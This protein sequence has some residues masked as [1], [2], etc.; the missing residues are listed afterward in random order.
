MK[1]HLP[2]SLG[3]V[4]SLLPP[5]PARP[6]D[7]SPREETGTAGPRPLRISDIYAFK[8]V[9]DP[10]ISPDGAWVAY[11]VK[12]LDEKEDLVE[13]S[14]EMA[15]LAGGEALPLTRPRPGDDADVRTRTHPRWSPDGKWLAFLAAREGKK[16]QVWLLPRAGGDSFPLTE[17]KAAVSDLAWSP[18]GTRLALVVADPDPDDPEAAAE[19]KGKPKEEVPPK[20]IVTRRLQFKQDGTG[21]LREL[22]DHLHVFDVRTRASVQVT[23]G[24]YDDGEPAWSPD[25]RLIAFTSNRSAQPDL[26]HNSDVF[27]VA[28]EAGAT[29][30]ALTT[31]PGEDKSPAWSPDGRLVAYLA[32]GE[33]ADMWYATNHVAVV[34]AAGGPSVPLTRSLDRNVL[35][36]RF[37]PDGRAVYFLLEDRAV[38]HLARVPASGGAVER[39]VA[40]E[41]DVQ[42]FDLG[43]KGE[44]VVLE[45]RPDRP[46]EVSALGPTVLRAVTG[47]NRA[48][49]ETIRLGPVE[50]H[51]ARTADGTEVD[52]FL[53][54]PPDAPA[55]ARLPTLLRIHGGPVSQY[56]ATFELDLQMLAAHGYAVVAPNPRGS[57][58]R[59]RDYSRAI[60]ADWGNKDFDDVT[61]AVDRAVELGVADP[62]RLGVGGWSY[63]GMMTNYVIARTARFKAAIAGAG[64]GLYLGNYGHDHYQRDW[65]LEVGLP[66]KTTDLWLKLSSPFL[67][68]ER[69]TTPT[70]YVCGEKDWNVPLLNTEQ[71]YQALRRLGRETELVVYPGEDHSIDRPSFQKDRYERMIG[72]YDRLVKGKDAAPAA[73]E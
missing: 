34:P 47:V 50:R 17:Y 41:R 18:D 51:Q 65:E 5:A 46:A 52:F 66:W 69:I 22:R 72:W 19:E 33:P 53:V 64:A 44:V 59:G 73:V 38:Q 1:L 62:A 39:P 43:P 49:L 71:M 61:A 42:A 58:G 68:V 54:R 32:G 26:N 6:R 56:A 29:P 25:G 12:S 67:Q 45:S 14:I 3:L 4:L 10:R 27:V 37:G 16:T 63:G 35:A 2:A 40:G 21:F 55:G 70:L 24:P 30:R 60:W 31:S 9:G 15:P 8:E 36:P 28:P 23:S 57:S 20:P 7:G 11:T 13:T 48:W